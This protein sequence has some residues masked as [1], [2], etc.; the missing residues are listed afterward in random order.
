MDIGYADE[1][2][3]EVKTRIVQELVPGKQL[4]LAHIIASPDQTLYE[5]LGLTPMEDKGK[6]AIGVMTVTPAEAAIII[7]DIAVKSAGVRLAFVDYISGSLIVS[8]TVSEVEAA[9]Q[10]LIDY[11]DEKLG[12]AVCEITRT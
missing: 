9:V 7:A 8:G 5:K 11:V 1:I 12:F 2:S 10:A 4:T 6:A 3:N